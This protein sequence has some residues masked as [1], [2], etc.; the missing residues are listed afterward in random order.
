MDATWT[1]MRILAIFG[2]FRPFSAFRMSKN[3]D[4]G[5]VCIPLCL[6][7]VAYQ[8]GKPSIAF[9]RNFEWQF[10]HQKTSG[11]HVQVK[12]EKKLTFFMTSWLCDREPRYKREPA[13]PNEPSKHHRFS[14]LWKPWLE[15]S[16]R[17]CAIVP[18]NTGLFGWPQ[19][20]LPIGLCG[21][22]LEWF[23]KAGWRSHGQRFW[24][25]RL[26]G[27]LHWAWRT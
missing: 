26:K 23:A 1:W 18:M 22:G 6:L 14:V 27:C 9:L 11:F 7:S 8:G 13:R 2:H 10:E 25:H 4:P 24:R 12:S 15:V 21:Y 17:G 19:C 16:F 3:A 20:D 5:F